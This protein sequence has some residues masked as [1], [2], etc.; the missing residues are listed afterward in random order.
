MVL[1]CLCGAMYVKMRQNFNA[2]ITTKANYV[3]KLWVKRNTK[4]ELESLKTLDELFALM[5]NTH[6]VKFINTKVVLM[7]YIP[8]GQM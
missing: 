1:I 8:I 6:C 3:N 2:L 5:N 7:I 4:F